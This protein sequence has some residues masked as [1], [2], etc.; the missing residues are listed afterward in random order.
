[1]EVEKNIPSLDETLY[2][3]SLHY[4][5]PTHVSLSG[6]LQSSQLKRIEGKST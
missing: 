5:V 3:H 1:M 6:E 2:Q 4:F